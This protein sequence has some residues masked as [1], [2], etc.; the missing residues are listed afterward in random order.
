MGN[1]GSRGKDDDFLGV[2][3]NGDS[4]STPLL[5]A[6]ATSKVTKIRALRNHFQKGFDENGKINGGIEIPKGA[7]L[8]VTGSF[9]NEILGPGFVVSYTDNTGRTFT[10]ISIHETSFTEYNP[11]YEIITDGG[12][13]KK[14]RSKRRKNLRTRRIRKHK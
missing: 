9:K 2:V 7:V 5:A 12:R 3:P 6:A 11:T 4:A 10:G 1:K 13:R 14:N 8:P